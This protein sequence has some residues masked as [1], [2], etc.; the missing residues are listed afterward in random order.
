[1][2]NKVSIRACPNG[3]VHYFLFHDFTTAVLTGELDEER[4][5]FKTYSR[6]SGFADCFLT[7]RYLIRINMPVA[8]F[9]SDNHS[10]ISCFVP[11][12]YISTATVLPY[13][14]NAGIV[15]QSPPTHFNICLC[16]FPTELAT[17]HRRQSMT[18][19]DI[20]ATCLIFLGAHDL[21][22]CRQVSSSVSR[23]LVHRGLLTP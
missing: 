17:I 10:S 23:I 5:C 4:H 16:F 1:M 8:I 20:L 13:V 18:F 21:S 9:C 22:R 6:V 7:T 2:L 14:F 15:A 3:D 19:R 12:L 11:T